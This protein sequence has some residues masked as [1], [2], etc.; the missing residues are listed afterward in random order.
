[1][2]VTR[3]DLNIDAPGILFLFGI[4]DMAVWQFGQDA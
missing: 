3:K 4:S 1:M 2:L